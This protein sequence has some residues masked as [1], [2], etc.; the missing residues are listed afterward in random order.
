MNKSQQ[1]NI[2]MSL[3]NSED[4]IEKANFVTVK[5]E[6]GSTG[7]DLAHMV[8]KILDDE[9]VHRKNFH[10]EQTDGCAA[11]LGNFKGCRTVLK[12]Y[13]PHLPDFKRV[14]STRCLQHSEAWF[15]DDDARDE[16]PLLLYLC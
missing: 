14:R 5:V 1:L 7:S 9:N 4:K 15:E 6:D 12:Q 8:L 3:R 10:S 13:L 16:V 2:N 11:M